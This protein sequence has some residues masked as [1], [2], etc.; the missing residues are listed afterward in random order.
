MPTVRLSQ[1]HYSTSNTV[2]VWTTGGQRGWLPD[3]GRRWIIADH[4]SWSMLLPT[5][6]S[7][8]RSFS[9][10]IFVTDVLTNSNACVE[11]LTSIRMNDRNQGWLDL[12]IADRIHAP[13]H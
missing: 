11:I 8:A 5:S 6:R 1:W 13:S 12:E 4:S 7:K 3:F 2:S 9:K 10:Q